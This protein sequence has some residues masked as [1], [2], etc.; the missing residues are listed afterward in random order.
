LLNVQPAVFSY[1]QDENNLGNTHKLYRNKGI[2]LLS[3]TWGRAEQLG[4]FELWE[5][6]SVPSDL[7]I[8]HTCFIVPPI[9]LLR[10]VVFQ[11]I[12]W[13][14]NRLIWT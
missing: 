6:W 3:A 14:A 5:L 12:T 11:L 2:V 7:V 8:R 9:W 10:Q 13:E 1:I 4:G